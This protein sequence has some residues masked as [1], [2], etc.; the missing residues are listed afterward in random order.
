MSRIFS[1]QL[2]GAVSMI[3]SLNMV[4]GGQKSFNQAQEL[5]DSRWQ[6]VETIHKAKNQ[7]YELIKNK[8]ESQEIRAAALDRYGRLALLEG[9]IAKDQFKVDRSTAADI[10]SACLDTAEYLEPKKMKKT[11]PE[12]AYWRAMCLGLW[13]ANSSKAKIAFHLHRVK[14]L[15]DLVALGM[16]EFPSFDGWGFHRMLAGIYLR[17][18]TDSPFYKP[19]EAF[20]NREITLANSSNNYMGYIL[21]AEALQALKHPKEAQLTLTNAI[22]E[23]K[24]KLMRQEIDPLMVVENRLFL[25]KMNE[26]LA[27]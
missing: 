9:E 7:F 11:L 18:D 14:E 8:K 20:T 10:F 5:F 24:G 3:F 23:L 1:F 19:E 27:H 2:I 6:G 13:F 21:R 17:C 4:A 15:T 22:G 12:Y 25:T 16:T 26:M